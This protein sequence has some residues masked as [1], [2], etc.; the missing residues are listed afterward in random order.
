MARCMRCNKF[1]LFSTK[2]GYCSN[3]DILIINENAE[4]ERKSRVEMEKRLQEEADQRRAEEALRQKAEEARKAEEEQKRKAEEERR[5]EEERQ[6]KAE[7]VRK[8]EEERRLAA[9]KAR[10]AEEERRSAAEEARKAEEERRRAAEEARKAEEERQRKAEL[11]RK[12]E[13][14]RERKAK[15]ARAAEEERHRKAEEDQ[16]HAEKAELENHAD[17]SSDAENSTESNDLENMTKEAMK[18]AAVLLDKVLD[19]LKSLFSYSC[20]DFTV[21]YRLSEKNINNY[22]QLRHTIIH[23][24][25]KLIAGVNMTIGADKRETPKLVEQLAGEELSTDIDYI[26]LEPLEL[27][28]HDIPWVLQYFVDIDEFSFN[29]PK[30]NLDSLT[31]TPLF[32]K[33][34]I[35]ITGRIQQMHMDILTKENN[36]IISEYTDVITEH[37]VD[38]AER[39]TGVRPQ[40]SVTTATITRN[41]EGDVTKVVVN[42]DKN[43][44]N[45]SD[46]KEG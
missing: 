44:G 35:S 39:I 43:K 37:Y 22:V 31:F 36:Q 19:L 4:K 38:E 41:D 13:E 24:F 11:A 27:S 23:Y 46:M 45:A 32:L 34:M 3:C 17:T 29:D 33:M 9:E 7:E 20:R 16:I 14:E 21:S 42:K 10:R 25:A 12:K 8:A 6:R 1:L 26:E 30:L 5:T 28:H 18:D 15:E 2:S 40:V